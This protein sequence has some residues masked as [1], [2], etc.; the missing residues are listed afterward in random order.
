MNAEAKRNVIASTLAINQE[1]IRPVSFGLATV[2]RDIPHDHLVG[3]ANLL[4][5]QNRLL[6]GE[7]SH[8]H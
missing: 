4:D 8:M 1:L 5:A 2:T 6:R 3:F 7:P